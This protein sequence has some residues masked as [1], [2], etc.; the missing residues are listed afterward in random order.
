LNYFAHFFVDHQLGQHEYNTGLLL[1][2]V[3]RGYVKTFKYKVISAHA[4]S[5]NFHQGCIAHYRADKLFHGSTFFGDLL[6]QAS[7]MITHA[8]FSEA[9][10]RR[11]FLAHILAELLIDRILITQFPDLLDQ[12]YDS[13]QRIH[14]DE[15]LQFL[16]D[17]EMKDSTKFFEFFNHFRKVQYIRFYTDNNKFVYS[18]NRIMI[19]AGVGAMSDSDLLVLQNV[20]VQLES[21]LITNTPDLISKIKQSVQ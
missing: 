21:L 17:Y 3:T 1:P 13:L 9:L 5:I 19:R 11:W 15:L 14:D 18:L 12:F 8:N 4:A 16:K 20:S 6:A 2:D 7:T 10:N